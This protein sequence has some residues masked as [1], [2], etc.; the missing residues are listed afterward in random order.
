MKPELLVM[1]A[2]MGSRYGGLKQLEQVGPSLETVMDYSLFD[3]HRAGIGRV[4]FVIRRELEQAF[5]DR[6]GDRYTRWMEVD[7]AFQDL[8]DLPG[9]FQRPADRLKPWGTGHAVLAARDAMQAPFVVVNA[10]DFYGRTAFQRLAAWAA[11]PQTEAVPSYAMVAFR[12]ANTLSDHGTV[13]R[14]ICRVSP[15]GRLETVREWVS[16]RREA[17]GIFGTDEE[18]RL[19]A[20]QDQVPVSMNCW[21]FN[22]SLFPELASRFASF[23]TE[24]G[25]DPK[26]EFFLPQV[27]DTLLKEGRASIQVLESPDRWFGVTYQEDKALVQ[28]E[29]RSLVEAGTYPRDLWAQ[30]GAR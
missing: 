3:A 26:A 17:E 6:I 25:N 21:G 22:P 16:L 13:A 7:Y 14:G 23:L 20:F 4:V 8:D 19:H 15:E 18:G 24:R 10:D 27:I 29:I 11:Q 1:A 9:G 2:G 28:A 5:R 12:L 30:G